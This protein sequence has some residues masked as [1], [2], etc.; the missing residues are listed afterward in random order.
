MARR[1]SFHGPVPQR[2]WA[3]PWGQ[4]EVSCEDVTVFPAWWRLLILSRRRFC[5]TM[6]LE[7][8]L[9]AHG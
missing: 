8:V 7:D 5:G 3:V 9:V 1:R 6:F 2:R 4:G